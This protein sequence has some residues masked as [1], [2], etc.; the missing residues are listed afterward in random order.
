MERRVVWRPTKPS[1]RP[2][3]A[4]F[5]MMRQ[6]RGMQV[7]SAAIPL[8]FRGTATL[9]DAAGQKTGHSFPRGL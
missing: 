4:Q 7:R 3:I 8:I 1:R 6:T 9:V 2:Q 5:P